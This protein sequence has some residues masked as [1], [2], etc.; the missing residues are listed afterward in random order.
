MHDLD[1]L[2]PQYPPHRR[3]IAQIPLVEGD[4]RGEGAPMAVDEIVQHHRPMT[5]GGKLPHAMTAD[6][7]GSANNEDVHGIDPRRRNHP[8]SGAGKPEPAESET[9]A[10]REARLLSA[11]RW[12]AISISQE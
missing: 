11:G 9:S 3:F 7:A 4:P 1:F 12:V 6:V 8:T 2:G 5:S 10:S